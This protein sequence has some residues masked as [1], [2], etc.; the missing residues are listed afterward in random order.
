MTEIYLND[1][2][3]ELSNDTYIGLNKQFFDLNAVPSTKIQHTNKFKIPRTPINESILEFAG[4]PGNTSTV[5]YDQLT[6]KIVD[7]TVIGEG[8]AIIDNVLNNGYELTFFGNELAFINLAKSNTIN[9]VLTDI[10]DNL[11]SVETGSAIGDLIDTLISGFNGFKYPLQS[12]FCDSS[13]NVYI[14]K[15]YSAAVTTSLQ[16]FSSLWFSVTEL[17]DV[18]C[19]DN[20]YTFTDNTGLDLYFNTNVTV[21]YNEPAPSLGGFVLAYP[22]PYSDAASYG[23]YTMLDII[24]IYA[25]KSNSYIEIDEKNKTI[26]IYPFSDLF[27]TADTSLDEKIVSFTKKFV[28]SE[29]A[30]SNVIKFKPDSGAIEADYYMIFSV[31]NSNIDLIKDYL[32]INSLAPKYLAYSDFDWNDFS[33]PEP[34]ADV[35]PLMYIDHADTDGVNIYM[36]IDNGTTDTTV[37]TTKILDRL[38]WYDG[39]AFYT[40]METPVFTKYEA[41]DAELML[42]VID[43]M[44][45]SPYKKYLFKKL[46]GYFIVNKASGFIPGQ[47]KSTKCELIRIR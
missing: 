33:F 13:K 42:N 28:S 17:I 14:S 7:G 43:Y 20:G 24:K 22:N 18:F 12:Q 1:Q 3:V 26:D 16:R 39:T 30:Q 6:C 23:N 9:S 36:K 11:D 37:S 44:N 41:V 45:L 19:T 5:Q 47:N 25:Q 21:K 29:Y 38:K 35:I 4:V 34:L 10:V 27:G 40:D 46:G 32:E 2:R 8:Y 15:Q 31:T